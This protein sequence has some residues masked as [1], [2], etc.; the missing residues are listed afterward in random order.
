M[1]SWIS[2]LHVSSKST[3]ETVQYCLWRRMKL[4]RKYS[5]EYLQWQ[6]LSDSILSPVTPYRR[7]CS[8]WLNTT[9]SIWQN[10]Y[11]FM[12]LTATATQVRMIHNCWITKP[13]AQEIKTITNNSNLLLISQNHGARRVSDS[14]SLS[15][16]K[17]RN[18]SLEESDFRL[19]VKW[20]SRLLLFFFFAQRRR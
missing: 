12:Y 19:P 6:P 3:L 4:N 18:R 9:I 14:P 15:Y 7:S 17:H 2:F 20:N 8:H 1:C 11:N 10:Y 13:L 5:V 16:E